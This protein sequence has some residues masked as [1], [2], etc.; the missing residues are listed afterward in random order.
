MITM[1]LEL[2]KQQQQ[3]IKHSKVYLNDISLKYKVI[4]I[5]MLISTEKENSKMCFP[6][7]YTPETKIQRQL[8]SKYK[9]KQLKQ[10]KPST[11]QWQSIT[12]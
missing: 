12:G 3:T 4:I 11:P 10:S 5:I 7:N 1:T 9:E 6:W 2:Q 8:I